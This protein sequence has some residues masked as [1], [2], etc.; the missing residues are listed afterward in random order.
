MNKFY[1]SKS[2]ACG[3][4]KVNN[5]STGNIETVN[6]IHLIQLVYVGIAIFNHRIMPVNHG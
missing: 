2:S 6:K 1:T 3:L 4:K 5:I